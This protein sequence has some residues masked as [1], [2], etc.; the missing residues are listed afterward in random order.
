MERVLVNMRKS[1]K[2]YLDA[3]RERLGGEGKNKN[4]NSKGKSMHSG[5]NHHT[6]S[7]KV[8]SIRGF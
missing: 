1:G 7:A 5:G 2:E 3:E 6:S 8:P 4:D